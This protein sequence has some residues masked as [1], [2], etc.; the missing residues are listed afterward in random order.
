M[1]RARSSALPLSARVRGS[2][3]SVEG[4]ATQPEDPLPALPRLRAEIPAVGDE[5]LL[6]ERE[7]ASELLA[8]LGETLR[9]GGVDRPDLLRGHLCLPFAVV[10]RRSS[11]A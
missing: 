1:A 2:Q 7:R 11:P 3:W 10:S 9:H 8:G 4:A 6:G 5:D